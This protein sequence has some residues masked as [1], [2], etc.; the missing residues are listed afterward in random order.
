MTLRE[1]ES[2][3]I[4][5]LRQEVE[6]LRR[7]RDDAINIAGEALGTDPELRSVGCVSAMAFLYKELW[8][9]KH[10]AEAQVE[11]LTRQHG[12]QPEHGKCPTCGK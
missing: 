4:S 9:D 1:S 12:W 5:R 11:T 6:T 10:T 8:K 7:E 3:L 2:D